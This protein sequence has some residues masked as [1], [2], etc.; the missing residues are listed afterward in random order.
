MP[1]V[2]SCSVCGHLLLSVENTYTPG[3]SHSCSPFTSLFAPTPPAEDKM[4]PL[5]REI[6]KSGP[7]AWQRQEWVWS[8]KRCLSDHGVPILPRPASQM[9]A[10]KCV[11]LGGR[12]RVFCGH[13]EA[14]A[15][16]GSASLT[17]PCCKGH[18]T[19][20]GEW[21]ESG[22]DMYFLK[23]CAR[24]LSVIRPWRKPMGG[25]TE[26]KTKREKEVGWKERNQGAEENVRINPNSSER[27]L[28]Q[29]NVICFNGAKS[30]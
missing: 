14:P 23:K 8:W 1:V 16:G 30:L 17:A 11:S 27:T 22:S 5:W 24:L 2:F 15:Q 25:R 3:P 6:P 9:P 28:N 4:H 29:N 20:F 18:V 12:W 21:R 13:P 19:C 26:T 10:T 7:R